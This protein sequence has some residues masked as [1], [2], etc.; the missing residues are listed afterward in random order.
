[1]QLKQIGPVLLGLTLV[2]TSCV[3]QVSINRRNEKPILV[4][5]GSITTDKEPYSVRLSYS[6]PYERGL[7]VPDEYLEKDAKVSISDDQGL[8]TTLT[9]MGNGVY[10]T[11]DTNYIG[12]AG[13]S[14]RLSI[15][16][17]NGKK[18][19]SKPEKMMNPVPISKVTA[20]FYPDN[21]FNYPTSLHVFIDTDDPSD[22]E[23]YYKWN[24][25]SWTQRQTHGVSCGFGCVEYEYCYQKFTDQETR[26]FSDASSNGNPIR[27]R[28]VG[29][30]Y[31]Y[32]YGDDFINIEQLSL[33]REGYQF[34]QRYDEQVSRTGSILDPLPSPIKGNV[35]NESDPSDFALGYFFANGVTRRR[36]QLVPYDITDY[37]LSLTA[38]KFIPEGAAICFEYFPNA[39][40]YPPRPAPQY[41]P[42]PGWENAERIE[43]HW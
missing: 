35:Y 9:H 12:Q 17:K 20:A 43:V 27:N 2:A 24:F 33:T 42:P 10:E 16:L 19:I 29:F 31:I 38:T 23:N 18:Y 3:K 22:E 13:R 25:Y 30:S 41:P 15:E 28:Q 32:T 1:M 5:E 14:Y 6:G 40:P 8:S 34:W 11:T 26:I 39:L 37:M 36:A 4:V 21:N 7:E